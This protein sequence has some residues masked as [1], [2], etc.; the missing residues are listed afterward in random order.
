MPVPVTAPLAVRGKVILAVPVSLF[1]DALGDV[2]ERLVNL[3]DQDQ[4]DIAGLELVE[5]RINGQ[6]FAVDFVNFA[7]PPYILESVAQ[8]SE[9]FTVGAG[10]LP[11]ASTSA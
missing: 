6:E 7:R 1:R 4:A 11:T 10:I 3:V 8:Q 5:R 2:R 9:Y